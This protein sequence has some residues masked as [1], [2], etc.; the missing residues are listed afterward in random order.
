MRIRWGDIELVMEQ[1]RN[2]GHAVVY[3]PPEAFCVEPQTCAIGAFN[4]AA[5]GFERS[6]VT[7]VTSEDPLIASTTWRWSIDT[8]MSI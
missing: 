8:A 7:T 3:T 1:S 6:G 4:L 2:L 5:R